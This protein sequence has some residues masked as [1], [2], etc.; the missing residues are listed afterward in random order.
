MQSK[1]FSLTAIMY[2]YS[3]HGCFLLQEVQIGK[4]IYKEISIQGLLEEEG[5]LG[6]VL[7]DTY[8]KCG[9]LM[10]AKVVFYELPLWDV[11]FWS[12][13][14]INC[15]ICPAGPREGSSGLFSSNGK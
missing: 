12:L 8:A 15:R 6:N 9:E 1:G 4:Q 10:K 14:C 2:G 7:I 3:L 5:V 13:E 11:I